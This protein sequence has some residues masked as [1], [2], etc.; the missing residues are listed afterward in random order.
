MK[1]NKLSVL[2]MLALGLVFGFVLSGCATAKTSTAAHDNPKWPDSFVSLG[3][4]N[5][6][7]RFG[8]WGNR[9]HLVF[10]NDK[11]AGGNAWVDATNGIVFILKAVDGD[12]YSGELGKI[13]KG[14]QVFEFEEVINTQAS[15]KATVSGKTMTISES[16]NPKYIPNGDHPTRN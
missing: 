2:G 5:G 4:D 11:N 10:A 15:F 16:T 6:H 3:K 12:A 7:T 14:S 9:T 8:D 13:V 1:K